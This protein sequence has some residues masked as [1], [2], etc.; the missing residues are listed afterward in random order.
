LSKQL[1][2]NKRIFRD[3]DFILL[4]I[5]AFLVIF[6]YAL[7]V[8]TELQSV[9]I[10]KI[11]KSFVLVLSIFSLF[12]SAKLGKNPIPS[13][14]FLY[15]MVFSFWVL[16]MTF[17]AENVYFAISR[18]MTFL[19]PF[20]YLYVSIH[21]LTNKYNAFALLKAFARSFNI[22]YAMPVF[23]FLL[24]GAGF[25]QTTIYGQGST[26][27]QF[28]VS[29]QYGWSCAV[30]MITSLDVWLSTKPGKAYK[31]FLLFTNVV[32][33]Y[34]VLISGNRASWLAIAL[35]MVIF[36]LR[37]KTIRTD[38]KIL[39]AI[40]PIAGIIWFYNL[41]DSSL[42]TRLNDTETQLETGEARFN[43]AKL[44]IS[45]F[46]ED[47]YLWITGA[48]MFNYERI[49]HGEGLGDYH[50][51]YLE[52]LFGG[53]IALFLMF[54]NFMIFRPFYY[55]AKYYSKYFL[56]ITPFAIIP[57]FESNLTGGQFLFYP[58]FIFMLLFNIPPYYDQKRLKANQEMLTKKKIVI[59]SIKPL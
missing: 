45:E 47:K 58:W 39:L 48:G 41:P 8:Y 13:P 51:S 50:N 2:E 27:G 44:A 52:V 54:I 56:L 25:S 55:Y 20:L 3:M 42:Q 40:L 12:R 33:F 6:G 38:F 28:L 16:L 19:L 24:S 5:N 46:N 26:E 30:F 53:G 22:I 49:I 29:N 11:V 1:S 59:G 43:T 17:F 57:F 7:A 18:S 36:A 10:M 31:I 35:A 23:L 21:N 15:M 9:G 14:T 4:N 32:A 34:L 37:L